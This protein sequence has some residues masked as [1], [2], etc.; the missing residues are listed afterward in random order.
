M[1]RT[2]IHP[3]YPAPE[4]MI[5]MI[6]MIKPRDCQNATHKHPPHLPD[7]RAGVG[8]GKAQ[9]SFSTGVSSTILQKFRR[10]EKHNGRAFSVEV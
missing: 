3:T 8:H 7:P 1:P 4:S 2:S 9:R 6:E 5:E 10:E